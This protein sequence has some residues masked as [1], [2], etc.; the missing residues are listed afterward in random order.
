MSQPHDVSRPL[1]A[2]TTV[3]V[4]PASCPLCGETNRC[5]EVGG[6]SSPCWCATRQFPATLLAEVPAAAVGRACICSNCLDTH[7]PETSEEQ[8]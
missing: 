5:A 8:S 1:D 4:D 2:G 7:D 6:S 3:D